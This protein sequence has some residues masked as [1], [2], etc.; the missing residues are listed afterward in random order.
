MALGRSGSYDGDNCGL[1]SAWTESSII[2]GVARSAQQPKM[3][4]IVPAFRLASLVFWGLDRNC[5]I[6]LVLV[7]NQ[8]K[9]EDN[10][11]LILT[12]LPGNRP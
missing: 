8:K 11:N 6:V 7:P 9:N 4:R 12:R 2:V 3:A 1:K 5:C 10:H